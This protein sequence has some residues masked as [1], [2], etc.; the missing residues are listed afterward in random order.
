MKRKAPYIGRQ[1]DATRY[2][3]HE[4]Y[5][6]SIPPANPGI[7]MRGSSLAWMGVA[8]ALVTSQFFPL[9]PAPAAAVQPE[10][11]YRIAQ[12]LPNLPSHHVPSQYQ[13]FPY[14]TQ[15]THPIPVRTNRVEFPPIEV[16]NTSAFFKVLSFQE[17]AVP[18]NPVIPILTRPLHELGPPEPL[19]TSAF[20]KVQAFQ[21]FQATTANPVI[22]ILTRPLSE[23]RYLSSI[24]SPSFK[25]YTYTDTVESEPPL[26]VTYMFKPVFR[27]R[28]R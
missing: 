18:A 13:V 25:P 23:L 9:V 10:I 4:G 11:P 19:N 7:P 12:V 27:P 16:A 15:P 28:R 14:F 6:V 20:F 21:A 1:Q 3:T 22:P 26:V 8:A 2:P 5:V 24:R 17:P